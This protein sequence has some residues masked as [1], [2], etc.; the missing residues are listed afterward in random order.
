MSATSGTHATAARATN[1]KPLELLARAGFIGYGIVHLLFAWLALQIAFGGTGQEGDQTGAM[2]TLAGQPFGKFLLVLIGVGM[3]AMALWQA[4]EAAVGHRTER[5]RSR[6]LER[7][8]SAGRTLVYAWFTWTAFKIVADAQGSGAD[9]QESFSAQLMS[10]TGGRWLVGLVGLGVLALGV[11]MVGYGWK[12]K[13]QEKLRT[14][15]MSARTR[16][17]ARRLGAAGYGAKG[18]VLAVAGALVVTAAVTYDP[19]RARGLDAALRTMAD[20]SWG[21]YL[22]ALMALGIVAFAAFCVIQA[23]YRKV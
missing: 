22:L 9:K 3:A 7:L 10:H 18:T 1:N 5:G 12:R 2:Q 8:S 16:T 11:G 4:L 6:V 15:R 21:P 19:E 23:R 13:F 17:L 14:E 20:H